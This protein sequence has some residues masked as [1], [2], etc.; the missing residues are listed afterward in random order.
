MLIAKVFQYNRIAAHPVSLCGHKKWI[1]DNSALVKRYIGFLQFHV[2]FTE[3]SKP[4]CFQTGSQK[5][6][7]FLWG[8]RLS[9]ASPQS[10][11]SPR[12][13][14]PSKRPSHK[15]HL[16]RRVY[17]MAMD[18]LYPSNILMPERRGTFF[19]I[20]ERFCFFFVVERKRAGSIRAAHLECAMSGQGPTPNNR[21]IPSRSRSS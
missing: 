6:A 3:Y 2:P 20:F 19:F 10:G 12:T 14:P 21:T 1:S 16:P 9:A 11:L 8:L 15:N 17:S 7:V 13:K 18:L 5:A 4:Y